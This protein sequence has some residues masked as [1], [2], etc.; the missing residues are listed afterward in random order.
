MRFIHFGINNISGLIDYGNR[1]FIQNGGCG[2]HYYCDMPN[3]KKV[4]SR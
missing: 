3:L 1:D 4:G 2:Y